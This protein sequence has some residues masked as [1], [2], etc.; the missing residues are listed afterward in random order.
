MGARGD[1][2]FPLYH[3]EPYL[4]ETLN[5]V[6]TDL[7]RPAGHPA[8]TTIGMCHHA[9]LCYVGTAGMDLCPHVYVVGILLTTFSLQLPH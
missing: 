3:V 9:W 8:P 1:A 4:L 2:V 5:P 7:A 6:V